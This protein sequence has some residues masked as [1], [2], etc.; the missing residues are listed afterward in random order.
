MHSFDASPGAR[1]AQRTRRAASGR[2]RWGQGVGSLGIVLPLRDTQP[3]RRL[4]VIT[5]LLIA[6]NALIFAW[7]LSLPEEQVERL[8]LACGVVPLRY[9]E[10]GALGLVRRLGDEPWPFLTSQFLHG[11]WLH[12]L[13]NMWMLWI[14]GDNVEDRL[15]RLRFLLFYVL[16][17][18]LAG[19]VH[20]LSMRDSLLPTIGASGAIAA[21]MGAY[22]VLYPRARIVTLLPI[23]LLFLTFDLPAVVFMGLWMWLQVQGLLS[24]AGP[25]AWWAHV[26]G[27]LVGIALLTLFL[28]RSRRAPS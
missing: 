28:P 9:T 3:H 21:V 2:I 26:G 4:P 5:L 22:M 8:I 19:V 14:F 16:G 24:G 6:A 12:L 10:H 20:T 17:G 13:G 25:I 7:E 1:L 27:F 18:V 15:G 23:P 11:D